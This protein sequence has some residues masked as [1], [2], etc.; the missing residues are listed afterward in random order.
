MSQDQIALLLKTFFVGCLSGT[1]LGVVLMYLLVLPVYQAML[2]SERE[3]KQEAIADLALA[4]QYVDRFA[5]G[6]LILHEGP[7]YAPDGRL[8]LVVPFSST[9]T[10]RIKHEGESDEY[11]E[12]TTCTQEAQS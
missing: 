10:A 9:P 3:W 4:T 11:F 1:G 8:A 7:C 6:V 5:D 12:A 2:D